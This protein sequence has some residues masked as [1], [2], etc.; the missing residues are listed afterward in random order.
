[1]WRLHPARRFPISFT[2][3]HCSFVLNVPCSPANPYIICVRGSKEKTGRR[4]EVTMRAGRLGGRAGRGAGG[5]MD[6]RWERGC[7]G[8]WGA[9]DGWAARSRGTLP[10]VA[11]LRPTRAEDESACLPNGPHRGKDIGRTRPVPAD[12]TCL[13]LPASGRRFGAFSAVPLRIETMRRLRI[14]AGHDRSPADATCPSLPASGR[15]FGVPFCGAFT[16]R[17]DAKATERRRLV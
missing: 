1:M 15:R 5:Q 13:S 9:R 2:R 3:S 10:G 14:A 7:G 11:V 17:N 4:W 12:S 6:P 16:N 8:A